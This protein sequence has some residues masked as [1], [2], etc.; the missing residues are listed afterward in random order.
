MIEQTIQEV[1]THFAR[2]PAK[3]WTLA[4]LSVVAVFFIA[5][6]FH[7]APTAKGAVV[8]RHTGAA[9]GMFNA[10]GQHFV[11]PQRDAA[12]WALLMRPARRSWAHSF[13]LQARYYPRDPAY[14]RP[15]V[16]KQAAAQ[17]ASAQV[18]AR[19][20]SQAAR[21]RARRVIR[22]EAALQVQSIFFSRNPSAVMGNT[23]IHDGDQVDGFTVTGINPRAVRVKKD[24]MDF[25]VRMH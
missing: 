23:I 10:T 9:Q 17:R 13:C 25:T 18:E 7:G 21:R 16:K 14:V 4:G 8:R 6:A 3:S 11:Q 20:L 15:V 1:K 5:R 24:G 22:Q 2:S 19:R 12:L